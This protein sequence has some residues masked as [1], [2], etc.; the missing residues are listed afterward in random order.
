MDDMNRCHGCMEV[1]LEGR[2][3]TQCGY[4]NGTIPE[5]PLFIRPGTK[6]GEYLFGKVLGHGGFGITYLGYDCR[7]NRTVAIKEYLPVEL[8]TRNP[9]TEGVSIF[10]GDQEQTFK[11]GIEKFK[12]EAEMLKN[13][14]DFPGIVDGYDLFEANNT[15]YFVMEYIV[16]ITLKEYAVQ[17]G[18][19]LSFE[20]VRAIL[21]PVIDA[22]AE[23]HRKD[24]IH[25]DISPDNIY[26]TA[27]KQVKLLDFGAAR[28]MLHDQDNGLTVILKH[29]FTPKEQ[30]FTKGNQGPWTDIYAL[31]ATAYFLMTGKVPQ[32]ALDR[33]EQDKLVPITSFVPVSPQVDAVIRKALAV[34]EFNRYQLMK[35]FKVALL[36]PESQAPVLAQ[37]QQ[38]IAPPPVY[39]NYS[40]QGMPQQPGYSNYSQQG[41]PQQPGYPNYSQGASQQPGYPNY[42]QGASQQ[43]GYP[44]YSQG[45]SQQTGYPNYS[46]QGTPQQPIN[47][48]QQKGRSQQPVP[49]QSP[50]KKK[51]IALFI[52]LPL[53]VVI[54]GLAALF[55]FI[56]RVPN[57]VGK[58]SKNAIE[59]VQNEGFSVQEDKLVYEYN[60][61]VDKGEVINQKPKADKKTFQKEVVL[62]VSD[63][64]EKVTV[65]DV[66]GKSAEE[67]TVTLMGLDF[68]VVNTEIFSLEE[69]GTVLGMDINSG[70]KVDNGTK[71]TLTISKGVDPDVVVLQ[72]E[73]FMKAAK[74]S[75]KLTDDEVITRDMAKLVTELDVSFGSIGSLEGIEAF[76]NLQT[77]NASDNQLTE[78]PMLPS[79]LVDINLSYNQL[80]NLDVSDLTNLYNLNASSNYL[81]ALPLLPTGITSLN[82]SNNDI[83]DIVGIADLSM[84]YSVDLSYNSLS[85]FSPLDNI[86]YVVSYLNTEGN[87]GTYVTTAEAGSWTNNIYPTY[88]ET[89][90]ISTTYFEEH[91]FYYQLS[92]LE[93]S[94]LTEDVGASYYGPYENENGT[95]DIYS[96]ENETGTFDFYMDSIT[97][98]CSFFEV[99]GESYPQLGS[100]IV[101]QYS[102]YEDLIYFLGAP[103]DLYKS[104]DLIYMDYAE[105]NLAYRF[106]LNQ[107]GMIQSLIILNYN[108]Y[109][110][111]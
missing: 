111:E 89:N 27:T 78:V 81:T 84:L 74:L 71:I 63:G 104:E 83:V 64:P 106:L 4:D 6:I 57:V 50:K 109:Y 76:A 53:L 56:P 110:S 8:A 23:M 18:G 30:Y 79:T 42:S 92:L 54:L 10:T 36:Y 51:H 93:T 65:P 13:F 21:M 60:D 95:F 70:E 47:P 22:L 2:F 16:G 1:M 29:G 31:G 52:C 9:D 37:P 48:N 75:M 90:T 20:T 91:E 58:S 68:E 86:P 40:Q 32:S 103:T 55:I 96:L 66:V 14:S 3:C 41:M 98:L 105:S 25:R 102:T 77:L 39:S 44:N 43:P 45:A 12:K 94:G 11:V 5:N 28:Q 100:D 15:A 49:N 38:A 69:V 87:V 107:E 34:E 24:I 80:N 26:I 61:E 19:R 7:N 46:Q 82:L 35:D 67:A 72:D 99:Y 33:I 85:D 88:L 59:T 101:S 17:M 108:Y 97:G 73:N 62:V